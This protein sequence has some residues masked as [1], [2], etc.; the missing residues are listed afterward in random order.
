MI[1]YKTQKLVLR[2]LTDSYLTKE[3]ESMLPP[4]WKFL[5]WKKSRREGTID[6]EAKVETDMKKKMDD[7]NST[8][9]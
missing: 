3:K 6:S 1:C 4:K 7:I 2:N 9:R 8:R 5:I